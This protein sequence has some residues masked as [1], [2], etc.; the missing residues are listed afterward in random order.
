MGVREA[1]SQRSWEIEKMGFGEAGSQR[2]SLG[3]D[4][5]EGEAAVILSLAVDFENKLDAE[6]CSLVLTTAIC[7]YDQTGV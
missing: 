2:C 3:D 1:G 5:V 6:V 7:K 4:M